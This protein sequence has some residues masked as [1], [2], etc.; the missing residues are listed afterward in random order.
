MGVCELVDVRH[1]LPGHEVVEVL[2]AEPLATPLSM[3][4]PP[5]DVE[6]ATTH[7]ARPPDAA[8][9][10]VA[11]AP[12]AALPS[13]GCR[14]SGFGWRRSPF[15]EPTLEVPSSPLL[16]DTLRVRRPFRQRDELIHSAVDVDPDA[17]YLPPDRP[18]RDHQG[19]DCAQH[20]DQL[21]RAHGRVPSASRRRPRRGSSQSPYRRPRVAGAR[22]GARAR[23]V[24]SCGSRRPCRT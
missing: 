16:E 24:G 20:G 12:S 2:L 15:D 19:G 18:E 13:S 7:T 3:P 4:P 1:V 8:Q 6:R 23:G 21:F 5:G 22:P 17:A 11:K 14:R 10:S 9:G